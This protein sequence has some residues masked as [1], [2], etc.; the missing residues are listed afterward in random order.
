MALTRRVRE[1]Q[2]PVWLATAASD[3][4]SLLCNHGRVDRRLRAVQAA[5]RGRQQQPPSSARSNTG[6]TGVHRSRIACSPLVTRRRGQ[7]AHQLRGVARTP[8]VLA[9][10]GAALRK[11]HPPTIPSSLLS[12]TSAPLPPVL[13]ASQASSRRTHAVVELVSALLLLYLQ[14]RCVAPCVCDITTRRESTFARA[15]IGSY[16][17]RSLARSRARA[18][19]LRAIT[20][21]DRTA[22]AGT[23]VVGAGAADILA[24]ELVQQQTSRR[25][26]MEMDPRL[27]RTEWCARA[28]GCD[29]A[30]RAWE[31]RGWAGTEERGLWVVAR[32]PRR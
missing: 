12:D 17:L 26:Q 31:D 27:G 21:S 2:R 28:G 3:A 19:T 32:G 30:R 4:P 13:A 6:E 22:G 25:G 18:L 16:T 8:D 1:P 24:V 10:G 9:Q 23:T 15:R 14:R 5:L 7:R 20:S 11:P 29:G